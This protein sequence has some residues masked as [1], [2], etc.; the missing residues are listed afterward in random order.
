M[1]KCINPLLYALLCVF[2][3]ANLAL[4]ADI[5]PPV[6]SM[7]VDQL[8]SLVKEWRADAAVMFYAPWCKACKCVRLAVS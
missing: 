2:G 8:R 1:R 3:V 5:L 7:S 6:A 4:G